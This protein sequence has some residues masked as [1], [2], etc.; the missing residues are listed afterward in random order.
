MNTRDII[1][2]KNLSKS[3]GDFSAVKDI[4]FTVQRG[5]IF[6]FLGPNGAG[7]TTTINMMIGLARSSNGSI[8]IDGMDA[9]KNVK[10]SQLIMGIV[11]DESNLYD[12]MDGFNNLY[13]WLSLWHE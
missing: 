10:K 6:G 4:S 3:Y 7:K 1:S 5:E 8:L 2:V 11:P 13:L 12:E 9:I